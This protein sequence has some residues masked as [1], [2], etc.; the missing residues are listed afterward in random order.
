MTTS[1]F[2]ISFIME[3]FSVFLSTLSAGAVKICWLHLCSEVTVSCYNT[4]LYLV[5]LQSWSLGGMEYP[6]L[7]FLSD[8]LWYRVVVPDRVSFMGQIELVNHLLRI[9]ISYLKPCNCVQIICIW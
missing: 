5:R 4:Q 7:P 6:S 1:C 3:S 8:P 9:I 2:L